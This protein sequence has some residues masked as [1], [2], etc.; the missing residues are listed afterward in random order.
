MKKIITLCALCAFV[1]NLFAQ[2]ETFDLTTYTP[3]RAWKKQLA[4]SAVQFTKEDTAKGTY[5]LITLFKAVPGTANSKENF[6]LAWASVVKEM[7]TV[8]TPPEMQPSATENGWE[9]QSGYAPFESDGNKGVVVLVTSSGFEKMVNLIILTNTDVYEKEMTDF[10]GSVSLKKPET[11]PQQNP[12]T[13]DAKN[14]ILGTWG[15]NA[16]DNSNYR[17]KNGIMNY[18]S[19]QYTFNADGSYS[20]V[21]KTFDPLVDRILLGKETGTYLVTGT[22]VSLNPKKS[23]LQEWSKMNGTDDWGKLMKTQ[24]IALEKATYQFTKHYFSGTQIWNLVLQA[25]KATQ[26]D[27]RHSSN[28]TFKNAWYYGPLSANNPQIK[29]PGSTS[30]VKE[31]A[32]KKPAAV[33]NGFAF[34]TTNFDDGW[35]SVAREDWVEATKANIKVLIHYPNKNAD[36]YTPDLME[37]LKH[38]WNVLVAPKYSS[39]GN[40]EFKP[41]S[42]WESIEFAEADMVEKESG[43]PVHVVLFKKNYSTGNGKYIEFITPD[44]KTF[45]QEYGTYE[46]ASANFGTGPGWEKMAG[47]ANYNK[48]AVAPSDLTGK[49]TSNFTGMTQY[50]NAYTGAS[51]GANT[52]ASNENFEFGAGNTYKWDLGV[53][54]GFVGNIKFQSA[55]STGKFTVI[56]NWELRLSDIEGKPKTYNVQFV[57]IKGARVLWIGE[58]GFGKK[59]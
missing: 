6:D 25:D 4:E 34:T 42:G 45:E 30:N 49:W 40:M 38:A 3:P 27:G 15:A 54:S 17:M 8:S 35:T 44:K 51:A 14:S 9:A 46:N 50:V 23:I 55:K 58:T 28:D 12:I 20:F 48:F 39:A 5:C 10:L 1:G 37:G 22:K 47:M 21:S 52:H 13:N 18:I 7:V 43:K 19:R 32:Q 16:S 11:I 2:K 33:S 41:A 53:A 56:N 36:D 31:E 57:C 59:E 26:R 24:N 29:L